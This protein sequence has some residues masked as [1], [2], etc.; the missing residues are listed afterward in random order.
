MMLICNSRAQRKRMGLCAI[1]AIAMR[2]KVHDLEEPR[3]P[4]ATL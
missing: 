2:E 1:R 4:H 3:P